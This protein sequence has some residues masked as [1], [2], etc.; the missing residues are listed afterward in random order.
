MTNHYVDVLP[1][2]H[3]LF[4]YFIYLKYINYDYSGTPHNDHP[5]ITY[6]FVCPNGKLTLFI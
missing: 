4:I 6:S 5:Y 1:L 3:Y 2:N